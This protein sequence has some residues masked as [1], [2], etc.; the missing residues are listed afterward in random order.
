TADPGRQKHRLDLKTS[1]AR[2]PV[3]FVGL[4]SVVRERVY[5]FPDAVDFGHVQPGSPGAAQTLM[6]YQSGGKGFQV[7]ARS[8]IPGLGVEAEPGP[9][10]DRVQLTLSMADGT[11]PGPLSGTLVLSTNDPEFPELSVAVSGA[12]K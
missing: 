9:Q 8:D 11:R 2:K 5:T 10:G 6:V 12:V 4:H 3:L 7:K 1:S